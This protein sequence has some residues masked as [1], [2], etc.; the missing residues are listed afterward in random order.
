[1]SHFTK[2]SQAVIKSKEAFIKAAKELGFEVVQGKMRGYNGATKDAEVV[3]R[4]AGCPYD[5]GLHKA[6]NGTFEMEADWWGVNQHIES[7][8]GASEFSQLTTKHT[9]KMTYQA[10]GFMVQESKLDDG[11]I[12]L[13]LTR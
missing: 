4:K 7:R 9:I 10:Q 12:K 8:D 3:V 13:R 5:V 2:V 6:E 11:S 1:M